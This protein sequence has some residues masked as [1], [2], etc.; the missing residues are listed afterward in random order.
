[1]TGSVVTKKYM[2][3]NEK[4][5]DVF[6][7]VLYDGCYVIRP[8][9]LTDCDTSQI[10]IAENKVGGLTV[11]DKMRDIKK[12]W[13]LKRD[14]RAAYM[15]LGIEYQ[16]DI[17]YAM[18]VRSMLYDALEYE[19]QLKAYDKTHKKAGDLKGAEFISG[20]S[21]ED[22][23][24]PIITLVVYFGMEK[25][26]GPRT[27]HEM[28]DIKDERILKYISDYK[29]NLIEPAMIDNTEKFR[30][31]FKYVVDFIK[32]SKNKKKLEEL[33]D[34]NSEYFSRVPHDTAML[35]KY[36]VDVDVRVTKKEEETNMCKAIEDMKEDAR[37][38]V[39]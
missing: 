31:D 5:A 13:I 15:M 34:D 33:V 28:F 25:W 23:L 30:S 37:E 36:C 21:K 39:R 22:K 7:Y 1:M 38:E 12:S 9:E 35:I 17:H 20:I 6:N 26:D 27:L 2:S 16:T 19:S 29:L 18:P 4:F 3:D 11:K 32:N 14:D 24:I 10:L 8:E